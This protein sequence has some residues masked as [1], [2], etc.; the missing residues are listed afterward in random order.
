MKVSEQRKHRVN[1]KSCKKLSSELLAFIMGVFFFLE[2]RMATSAVNPTPNSEKK[3]NT[4]PITSV[5][6]RNSTTFNT[7]LFLPALD[8]YSSGH[9]L[10]LFESGKESCNHKLETKGKLIT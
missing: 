8:Q 1:K 9:C 10:Q 3:T 4:I 5:N 7:H 2:N 6:D